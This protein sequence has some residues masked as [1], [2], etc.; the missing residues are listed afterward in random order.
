MA[1]GG[2][3]GDKKKEKYPAN[4]QRNFVNSCVSSGGNT[5]ACKCAL[6]KIEE[7]LSFDAYKKEETAIQAG[8]TPSRKI[9]DSV[10]ECR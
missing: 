10:A 4:V 9:T 2:C 7:K 1:A 5:K 8:R 6:S 3:G